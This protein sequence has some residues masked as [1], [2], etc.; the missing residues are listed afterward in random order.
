MPNNIFHKRSLTPGSVPTTSSLNV[1][2]IAINVPDGKIFVEKSGSA[3]QSIETVLVSNTTTDIGI[4]TLSGSLILSGSGTGS[5]LDVSAGNVDFDFDTLSFSGSAAITG[6]LIVTG[7]IKGS[8]TGTASY[9]SQSL[10]SSYALS[11]SYSTIALNAFMATSSSYAVSASWAPSSGGGAAFPYTG[12][13]LITGS[14]GVTG[15]INI[16]AAGATTSD[17]PFQVRNSANTANIITI[18]GKGQIWSNGAGFISSNTSYGELA[19][20]ANTTGASNTAFGYN[21]LTT[22][23]TKHFQNYHPA[24]KCQLRSEYYLQA[25]RIHFQYPLL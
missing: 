23:T 1:G 22:N 3:G 2:E 20:T 7:G 8:L 14:L 6:S 5:V 18:T 21:T 15:S 25:L 19:L 24:K 11:A 16:K 17:L 13:A 10:S 9:A 12:S 4:L